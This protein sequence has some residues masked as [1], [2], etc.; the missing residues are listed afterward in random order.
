MPRIYAQLRAPLGD[1]DVI[2]VTDCACSIPESIREAFLS[3]KR[4]VRARLST[5]VIGRDAG[6]LMAISDDIHQVSA[7]IPG[8]AAVER[9]LSL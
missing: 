8:D 9:V 2:F 3:W 7:L 6:D 4:S 1:T 5:L